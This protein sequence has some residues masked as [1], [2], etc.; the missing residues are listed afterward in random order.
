VGIGVLGGPP[1]T[2]HDS[3]A[4]SSA[5]DGFAP[6]AIPE[7]FGLLGAVRT[8]VSVD[9]LPTAIWS[10]M[11]CRTITLT[12]N[13]GG[14]AGRAHATYP[15]MGPWLVIADK[16]HACGNEIMGMGRCTILQRNTP[17]GVL[18]M[19]NIGLSR[20]LTRLVVLGTTSTG[21]P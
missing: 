4:I 1:I 11:T 6:M 19:E 7:G 16:P 3:Q 15:L 2:G 20:A 10:D 9:G 18:T 8:E 17:H 14:N 12:W 5:F 13:R 21:G